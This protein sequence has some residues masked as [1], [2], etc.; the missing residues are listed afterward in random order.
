MIIHR[1][2]QTAKTKHGILLRYII[3]KNVREM[4]SWCHSC[5]II[6]EFYHDFIRPKNPTLK[7]KGFGYLFDSAHVGSMLSAAAG[8]PV[9]VSMFHILVDFVSFFS[10]EVK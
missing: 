3:A 9:A 6:R 2:W 10:V 4:K 1:E 5:K 8:K 7:D